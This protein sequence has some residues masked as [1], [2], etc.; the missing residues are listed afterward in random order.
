MIKVLF[1]C[2]GRI[3][4]SPGKACKINDFALG[5]GTYYTTTI[6]FFERKEIR[7][8]NFKDFEDCLQDRCTEGIGADC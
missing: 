2:H 6:P 7:M 8:T 1:V 4:K 3:L 5:Y